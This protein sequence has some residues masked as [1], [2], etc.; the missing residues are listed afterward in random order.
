MHERLFIAKDQSWKKHIQAG[1]IITKGF[2]S[3]DEKR[4]VAVKITEINGTP[5]KAELVV[6]SS[7]N[8]PDPKS[9]NF[10]I[11]VEEA[12]DLLKICIEPIL[13]YT[14]YFFGVRSFYGSTE[15]QVWFLKVYEGFHE[16][17]VTSGVEL[18][19]LNETLSPPEWIG[20]EVTNDPK[21][22]DHNI[23]LGNIIKVSP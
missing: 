21:Y 18:K 7:K 2:L 12:K 14:K 1:E 23:A 6:N 3:T 5:V 11:S 8:L 16:G 10:L 20:A 15:T 22:Q 13:H 17:F 19:D 4:I 9:F